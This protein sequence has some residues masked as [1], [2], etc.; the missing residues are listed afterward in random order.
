[1]PADAV[2][3]IDATAALLTAVRAVAQP[4]QKHPC[5]QPPCQRRLARHG[6]PV[7]VAMPMRRFCTST[8]IHPPVAPTTVWPPIRAST[9]A[10]RVRTDNRKS[11]K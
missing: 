5:D 2:T 7:D 8:A 6:S 11:S 4:V 9:S 3:Q 10:A 1:M